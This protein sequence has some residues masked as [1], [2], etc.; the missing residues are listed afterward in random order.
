MEPIQPWLQA[1]DNF[2]KYCM[3]GSKNIIYIFWYFFNDCASMRRHISKII[4]VYSH[5][6]D[7]AC[8]LLSVARRCKLMIANPLILFTLFSGIIYEF[9]CMSRRFAAWRWCWSNGHSNMFWY[10]MS[11]YFF[12]MALVNCI[13][14]CMI[15]EKWTVN[16]YNLLYV[17]NQPQV[18]IC[19]GKG[20]Y[21]GMLNGRFLEKDNI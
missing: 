1:C 11:N 3:F 2:L 15:Q 10:G 7:C 18:I 4:H 8:A 6:K 17:N 19:V 12:S 5:G 13:V 14:Y 16:N 21:I 9:A 20:D